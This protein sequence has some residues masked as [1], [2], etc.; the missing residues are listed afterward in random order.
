MVEGEE[1]VRLVPVE[2]EGEAVLSHEALQAARGLG[3][4]TAAMDCVGECGS[5]MLRIACESLR[6]MLWIAKVSRS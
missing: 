1:E 3:E 6:V 4:A 2:A 5:T